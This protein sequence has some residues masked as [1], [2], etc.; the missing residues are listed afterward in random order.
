MVWDIPMRSPPKRHAVWD[1]IAD[2]GSANLCVFLRYP[3]WS[4]GPDTS[5]CEVFQANLGAIS[6][7]VPAP[8]WQGGN[9]A[10]H[11]DF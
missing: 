9:C 6:R 11:R 2:D 4:T 8:P 10:A 3:L 5:L 7:D 1:H